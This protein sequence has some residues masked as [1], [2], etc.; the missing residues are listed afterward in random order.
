MPSGFINY[1]Y[2]ITGVFGKANLLDG[3]VVVFT[4]SNNFHVSLA[5]ERLHKIRE[6]LQTRHAVRGLQQHQLF[7]SVDGNGKW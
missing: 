6:D 4:Q 3:L 5:E 2:Y 1:Y 7:Y